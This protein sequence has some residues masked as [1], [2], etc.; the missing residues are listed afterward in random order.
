MGFFR[1]DDGEVLID[2]QHVEALD[3]EELLAL[4]S[5]ALGIVFQEDAL[6]TGMSVYDNA[7]F[8]LAEH[9]WGEEEIERAVGEIL[10]FVGL[11]R[12]AE[13]LPEELS[14]GMR[15]RLEIARALAGW[16]RLMLYDEP[17]AGLDPLTAKRI[18]E[19]VVRARDVHGVSA[20]YVTKELHE[21][22]Y[23][24]THS[25]EAR[26]DG[27]VAFREG[28]P[29]GAPETKVMLLDR[30]R[31]ALLGSPE[32]L[33]TSRLPAALEMTH[34]ETAAG[35]LARLAATGRPGPD[36]ARNGGASR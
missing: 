13:K 22:P 29:A 6:F 31:V 27:S 19:L 25:A 10:A 34:P 3:E 35:S 2:G 26:P 5:E 30:G 24:A 1:P 33:A 32:E 7:A 17:T 23:L 20:L 8:R 28:R 21:I 14:I 16:P 4:R 9:G 11:D 12:D 15:R 36:T 18:M